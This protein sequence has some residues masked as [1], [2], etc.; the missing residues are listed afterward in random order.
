MISRIPAHYI[1]ELIVRVDLVALIRNYVPLQPT[2]KGFK[3]RCPFHEE[4]TPSFHVVPDKQFYYCFGCNVHGTAITFL[5]EFARLGFAEAIA[6]LAHN[7]GM[8]PPPHQGSDN[9][10]NTKPLLEILTKA[11]DWYCQQL[12]RHPNA[13][14]DYL[15]NRGLDGRIAFDYGLG[16][17]P[18]GWNNLR[19]TLGVDD[20]SRRLL[21]QAGL[22]VL[23]NKDTGR[24]NEYDR[25]R[26]RIMF[27]IHNNGG[28]VIGFGGRILDN[29]STEAKYINSPQSAVFQKG[30]I[31]YGL[32]QARKYSHIPERILVVEGYMD[33]VSLAQ[34]DLRESVATLGTAATK[35]QLRQLFQV[36]SH[37]IFCFDGD[38]AG[39]KAA[40]QALK[41]TLPVLHDG[42]QA[43]FLFL[44]DGQ[45]P[46]SLIR[47]TSAADFNQ[48]IANAIPTSDYLFQTLEQKLDLNSPEGRS[49]MVR[50]AQPLLHKIPKGSYSRQ[51]QQRL[52]Q[53]SGDHE[54]AAIAVGKRLPGFHRHRPGSDNATEP[55]TMQAMRILVHYPTL[56]DPQM[57]AAIPPACNFADSANAATRLLHELI[58]ILQTDPELSPGQ[59]VERFRDHK[60]AA[61]IHSCVR[62]PPELHDQQ[63]LTADLNRC[64]QGITDQE[65]KQHRTRRFKELCRKNTQDLDDS[66]RTELQNLYSLKSAGNKL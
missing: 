9:T 65:R 58:Q 21:Q 35:D 4:K 49:E 55:L 61:T 1:D 6:Q 41:N 14:V 13:A 51:M 56:I 44:P 17:A 42:K 29:D 7:A 10:P 60:M 30:H 43:S 66:E 59:L 53:L 36:H 19:Q 20:A 12:R 18:P 8:P 57:I 3:G 28:R 52:Q 31:L 50:T 33:V 11:A 2:G 38:T 47:S 22:T 48:R 46:D 32:H 62:N 39:R 45:D 24:R 16:Y 27:P 25:F 5:M 54:S 23:S 63:A 37:V 34:F 64:L 40:W 26:N 15:K